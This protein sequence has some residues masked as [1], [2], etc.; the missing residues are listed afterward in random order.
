M[1]DLNQN[2]NV[3]VMS[4]KDWV[5]TLL[6]SGIPIVGI[7]MIFVWAFGDNANPNKANWAKAALL[8]V[9]IVIGIY[10]L[11]FAVFGAAILGAAGSGNF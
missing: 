10:I 6:I 3:P 11:F 5:I 9:L 4:T 2:S 8:M 1:E 7:V